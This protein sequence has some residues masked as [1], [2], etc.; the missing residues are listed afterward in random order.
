VGRL[1]ICFAK[2]SFN[3]ITGQE[4]LEVGSWNMHAVEGEADRRH[5][6]SVATPPVVRI[7]NEHLQ[8]FAKNHLANLEF[9]QL[10]KKKYG[11]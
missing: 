2:R 6:A 1:Q 3:I 9:C 11:K 10:S 7:R 4:K 5:G 8:D